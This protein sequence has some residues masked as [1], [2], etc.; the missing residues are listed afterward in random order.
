VEE[1]RAVRAPSL[2]P[3]SKIR[4]KGLYSIL[5]I[6]AF[7]V[8]ACGGAAED[9]ADGDAPQAGDEETEAGAD[10]GGELEPI[11]FL[12]TNERSIQYH[13]IHIAQE[14][15]YFEDEGL[16]ITVEVVDGSSAAL[17]Q[18]IA[19][20]GDLSLP[21][22]PAVVQAVAQGHD[23]VWFYTFF[24][25]NVFDLSAPTDSGITDL[26]GLQGKTIGISEP[27]GGEV[28]LVRGAMA[29]SGL[30][31]GEDYQL[32]AIGEG[33]AST[34]EALQRGRAHAYSSSVFDVAAVEAAGMELTPLLPDDFRFMPS[35]GLV[36]MRETF[37][38]KR[39]AMVGFARAQAKGKVFADAN[40]EAANE[41][42]EKY[43][44]ELYEDPA[45]AESIWEATQE[46]FTP[47][48]DIDTDP[49]Q[50]MGTHYLPG[51]DFYLDFI[52]QGTEEEGAVPA[53]TVDT[54]TLVT[55]ELLDEINDFDKDA[56][57]QEAESYDG[58]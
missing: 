31:E 54:A 4:S 58:S 41:I 46:L 48:E 42:A 20:N 39:D 25:Q 11:T 8:A 57:R 5:L 14:L 10:A 16:D 38:Q 24:Y 29:G 34:F 12:L 7:M 51:W 19:G 30:T 17:Q 3:E 1:S 40:P 56:V 21:S 35:Q 47:P 44:P 22:A 43:G 15:G 45:F 27:S 32:L 37:E 23:P 52:S 50:R 33:D 18:L 9:E 2:K 28:P 55:D 49:A 36:A 13:P 6:L 26:Q 53:G